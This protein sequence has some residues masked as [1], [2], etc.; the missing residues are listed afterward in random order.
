MRYV[1]HDHVSEDDDE[2]N[3]YTTEHEDDPPKKKLKI[4]NTSLPPAAK[5]N[6]LQW[7]KIKLPA[8]MFGSYLEQDCEQFLADCLRYNPF[9]CWSTGPFKPGYNFNACHYFL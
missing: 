4:P 9:I 5:K 2:Q 8:A 1:F 7:S 3:F 6:V